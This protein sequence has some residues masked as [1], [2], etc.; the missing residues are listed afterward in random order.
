MPAAAGYWGRSIKPHSRGREPGKGTSGVGSGV[1]IIKANYEREHRLT[2]RALSYM[3]G[4]ADF[5]LGSMACADAVGLG[6]VDVSLAAFA[7]DCRPQLP[8]GRTAMP[9]VRK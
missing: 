8:A 9:A 6:S 1:L 5:G 2:G 3:A 7:G 4:F